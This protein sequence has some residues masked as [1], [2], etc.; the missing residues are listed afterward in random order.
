MG[1]LGVRKAGWASFRAVWEAY[2]TWMV[3]IGFESG[4]SDEDHLLLTPISNV[5]IRVKYIPISKQSHSEAR[6][7]ISSSHTV[8]ITQ[9]CSVV[10]VSNWQPIINRSDSRHHVFTMFSPTHLSIIILTRSSV[11]LLSLLDLA[12]TLTSP[13]DSQHPASC[14]QSRLQSVP[15]RR[16]HHPQHRS[17]RRRHRCLRRRRLGRGLGLRRRLGMV[18]CVV[19]S[20]LGKG[21]GCGSG[22]E[23]G[24]FGRAGKEW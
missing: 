2:E 10:Y 1:C 24:G 7:E 13:A 14:L 18:R 22:G 12:L 23:M 9:S 20:R 16:L 5:S 8:P 3:S 4:R 15:P 19:W 6:M 17:Q 21:D 11:P